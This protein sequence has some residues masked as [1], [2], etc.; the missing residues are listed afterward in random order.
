MTQN[1]K[2]DESDDTEIENKNF[3]WQWMRKDITLE[4][5]HREI[6]DSRVAKGVGPQK[7]QLLIK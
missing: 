7:R 4:T 5:V 6:T 2:A 1:T 3:T